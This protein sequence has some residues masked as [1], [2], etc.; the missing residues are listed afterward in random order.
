[1]DEKDV[2]NK[3]KNVV[4]WR[5]YVDNRIY[6]LE[7]ATDLAA[8][9]LEKRLEGMN[10]FREALKNQAA[11]FVTRNEMKIQL[12]K[13]DDDI[14]MLREAKAML[15]GKASQLYVTITLII[16]LLGLFISFVLILTKIRTV[17]S[18]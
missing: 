2:N 10:E 6:A 4:S 17:V 8:R 14:R 11:L 9:T 3:N 12:D 16:S 15:E 18:Q 7:K 5:D 1:M 13:I